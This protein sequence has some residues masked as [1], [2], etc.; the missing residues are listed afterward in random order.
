MLTKLLVWSALVAVTF[1]SPLTGRIVGGADAGVGQFPYQVSLRARDSHNCGGSIIDKQWILTA[2]HCVAVNTTGNVPYPAEMFSIRA[3]SLNRIAGGVIHDVEEVII[4]EDRGQGLVDDVA[5]LK[6]K[7]PLVYTDTIKPIELETK[8]IADGSTILLSGWGLQ[9]T[10]GP[11][12]P[13]NLQF[14]EVK[15]LSTADCRKKI[16]TWAE[17]I[18]CLSHPKG[19]GACNGDSGGPAAYEGKLAGIAGFVTGIISKCGSGRPDGYAKV[20]SHIEWIRA[21]MK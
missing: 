20:S 3:G 13:V 7:T 11:K 17:S 9:K 14:V 18:L 19:E 2:A 15:T 8:P 1:A 12:L 10:N 16:G 5:L 6:L 21:H 4:H